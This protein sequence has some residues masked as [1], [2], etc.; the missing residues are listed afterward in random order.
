MHYQTNNQPAFQYLSFLYKLFV[1]DAIQ[2][3]FM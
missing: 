3:S 1:A 2:G